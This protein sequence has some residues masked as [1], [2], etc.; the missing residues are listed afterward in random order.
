MCMKYLKRD[1][2]ILKRYRYTLKGLDCANCAREIEEHL[3]KQKDLANVSV[4]FSTLKLNFSTD[5]N[6][7]IKEYI[8]KLVREVEPDV[9][10]LEDNESYAHTSPIRFDVIR[11][12]L[13]LILVLCTYIFSFSDRV[14]NIFIILAYIVLLS[15]TFLNAIKLLLKGTINESLLIT[16]SCIGAYLIGER[17]EGLM[18]IILYEFGKILEER[19]INKSRKSISSLLDIKPEYALLENGSI[20]KPEEVKINEVIIVKPGE[21][22]PLDGVVISGNSH[23]NMSSLTGE[24][25]LVEV[26]E[27]MPI[28]SGAIN[29]EGV[30]KI[31]VTDVYSNST[32]NKILQ[33]VENATD[34]KTKTETFVNK[35]SKIYTPIVIILALLVA[36]LLPLITDLTYGTSIYR[37]LTF[38]VI[39]CPC[40]IAI[41]VPLS[42]FSGIGVAS[43]HGILIK[44]SNYLDNLSDIKEIVFDKTGT[45]TTGIF[46]VTEIKTFG[47]YKE[48]EVLEF[49]ALGESFSN[50]PIAHSIVEYYGK[51]IDSN[52]VN[53]YHEKAGLGISYFLDNKVIKVG[54]S[55]FVNYDIELSDGTNVFV[56]VDDKVVGCIV[57]NDVIKKDAQKIISLLHNKHI[58]TSMFTGDNKKAALNVGKKLGLDE[59][60]YE[61][62]PTDK[63]SQ[64]E[65]KIHEGYKVAFVGDGIN[66][67][68]V[69]ALADIGISMGLNG[70]SAAIEA[71]DI[72]IMTD[73]LTKI[74]K[75]IDISI[76]T[77]KIIKQ[78]LFFALFVKVVILILSVLGIS[79]MWQAIFA[80]VG[81]T[82]ITI[83]NTLRILKIK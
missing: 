64:L 78:N 37:A 51:D 63:Y 34:K 5:R 38:L 25:S 8:Q 80:D 27:D 18:V 68:P 35:V 67:A 22:V 24:S 61:M 12:I 2:N 28:L 10:I 55:D 40:A 82:L 33:L 65:E 49:A 60:R 70:T 36:I 17:L 39:S 74:D 76:F 62:L 6:G 16:I 7:N 81:V 83:F 43:K 21:K 3:A 72:V 13:G 77:H 44:G 48:D 19:A 4:N 73:N 57:L 14:I 41:S 20:I 9:K 59:I 15:R 54:N 32:V 69:L 26:K 66:D 31:K 23:L 79:S 58:K 50:H 47:H 46:G 71:S 52:S 45:L 42:Y 30:L 75:G 56:S 53:N 11:L 29:S 1:V